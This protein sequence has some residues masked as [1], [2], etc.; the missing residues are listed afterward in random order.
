MY[1][2]GNIANTHGIK[3]EVKIYNLS[4]FSRFLVSAKIYVMIKGEK[5]YFTIEKVRSQG[6]LF[7]VKF[8]GIDNIN[9]VLAYKGM[10]VFSDDDV[11]K[12]L[13]E[14]DYHY[15]ALID[16]NVYSDQ[17]ELL[18]RVISLVEV[19][20]GHLMEIEKIDGKKAL[21]PFVKAFVKEVL[22]DRVIIQPIEGLL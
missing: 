5:K 2:I 11:S 8:K 19:P 4:D 12:Q 3:G 20:Q 22:S 15:G 7:V 21:V 6:N 13:E 16:K 9:D 17:G 18:G 14:D 1:L 10:D